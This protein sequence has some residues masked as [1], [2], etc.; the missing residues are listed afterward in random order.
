MNRLRPGLS[1][2]TV[3]AGALLLTGARAEFATAQSANGNAGLVG[4]QDSLFDAI[5]A[6]PNRKTPVPQD[7][8]F[9]TAPSAE[10]AAP[11]PQSKAIATPP[12]R[13]HISPGEHQ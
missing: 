2:A 1:C 9:A 10:Q 5:L 4:G 3:L 8:I 11:T 7:N 6:T 13:K 12:V